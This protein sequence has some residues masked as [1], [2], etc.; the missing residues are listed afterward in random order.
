MEPRPALVLCFG[1]QQLGPCG[2]GVLLQPAVSTYD[3]AGPSGALSTPRRITHLD[4]IGPACDRGGRERPLQSADLYGA[5][6]RP[7]SAPRERPVGPENRMSE[8][9]P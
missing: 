1:E 6:A 2:V 9:A 8:W 7:P 4:G 5:V 3:A